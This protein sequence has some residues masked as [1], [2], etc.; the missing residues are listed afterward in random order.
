MEERILSK[1]RWLESVF[2]SEWDGVQIIFQ[3]SEI[4]GKVQENTG[5]QLM[6]MMSCFT[7]SSQ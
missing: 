2:C 6:L 4:S 7:N 1:N 5:A 3:R